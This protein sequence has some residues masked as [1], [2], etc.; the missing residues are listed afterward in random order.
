M[1]TPLEPHIKKANSKAEAE[2][3]LESVLE[4]WG[5]KYRSVK[6]AL[7]ALWD[8]LLSFYDFPPE[9]WVSLYTPKPS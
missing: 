9:L 5:K 7:L 8:D 6:K 2:R 4:R 1:A 3:A